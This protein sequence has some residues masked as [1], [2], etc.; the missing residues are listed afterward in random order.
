M[1]N[2]SA[3]ERSIA[4]VLNKFPALKQLIKRTYSKVMYVKSRKPYR[5]QTSGKIN[6]ISDNIESF[7][8]YYD[9]TPA[10]NKGLV[11]THLSDKNT[12]EHPSSKQTIEVALYSPGL[13]KKLWSARTAAYTWQQGARL[14]WLDDEYFIYNDFDAERSRYVSKVVNA[15]TLKQERV[16]DLP[17]QDSAGKNYF[18]SLN[19]QRLMALRPDYGYR[20]IVNTDNFD[21]KRL[22]N[23]GIWKVDYLT[24]DFK[25]LI[26]LEDIVSFEPKPDFD[27]AI[28]KVNH[29]MISPLGD[30]FIFMHRYFIGRRRFDRLLLANAITGRLS[31][32]SAYEMVSHCC[33]VDNETILGYMRGPNLKDCYWLLNT[34]NKQFKELDVLEGL[35]D[36]HPHVNGDWF[37]TDTYP[38]KARM[39]QLNLVNWKNNEVKFLGEFFHGFQYNGECR[40]DLHPRLSPCGK[41]VYFDSVYSGKRKLYEMEIDV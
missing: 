4:R 33:W 3:L 38:D 19:Y 31:E 27:E 2:Y 39:Q 34:Q 9:K 41:K 22:D 16:F 18:L 7:F 15:A 25:L 1:S 20:N 5:Y 28:H 13:V 8:G 23:D 35:G 32:L 12:T 36:G 17:V 26:S 29:I 6:F 24:G 10:N 21:L 40:C 37:I 11:L 30:Q 14:H